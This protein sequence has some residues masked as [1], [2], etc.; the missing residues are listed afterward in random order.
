MGLEYPWSSQAVVWRLAEELGWPMAAKKHVEWSPRPVF[1]GVVTD[2]GRLLED[3]EVLL[4]PKPS[5]REKAD[6]M[7][8]RALQ[9][10]ELSP[11]EARSLRGVSRWALAYQRVGRA[12]LQPLTERSEASAPDVEV[13]EDERWPLGAPLREAL[14]FMR[15]VLFG[16][17]PAAVMRS[18][19]PVCGTPPY[20]D[21]QLR[22]SPEILRINP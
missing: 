2:F 21:K 12:A 18:R 6:A 9:S 20:R 7:A 4:S 3:G 15:A 13:A 14:R 16:D 19:V 10:G 1:T 11:A 22:G 17:F 8:E 5:T